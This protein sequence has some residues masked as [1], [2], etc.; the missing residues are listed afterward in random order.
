MNCKHNSRA[1]VAAAGDGAAPPSL[2][3]I[4][5]GRRMLDY[6]VA[7]AN[8]TWQR[9]AL[10][11]AARNECSVLRHLWKSVMRM[12]SDRSFPHPVHGFTLVELLVVIAIIA[13]LVALLLPAVNAAREAGRRAQCTNNLYNL[14]FATIRS[15][16]TNGFVPGWRNAVRW[17]TATGNGTHFTSWPVPLLPFIERNDVF[18]SYTSGTAPTVFVGTFSCPSSPPDVMTDA[19]LA[20]AG[21]AGSGANARRHD[22]VMLDTTDTVNGRVS[23][24]DI[25]NA[26]GTTQ[27]LLLSEKCN[28]NLTLA[29]NLWRSTGISGLSFASGALNVTPVFGI[30]GTPPLRVINSGTMGSSSVPGQLSM[31]SSNHSGGAVSAFCDGHTVFL[32]E[33]LQANVYAQL[34][35]SNN[36]AVTGAIYATGTTWRQTYNILSEGDFN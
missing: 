8:P 1:I 7:L 18:R 34:L 19:T 26:D 6:A 15:N 24:D 36:A 3:S 4:R 17:Q 14:A 22:A 12:N 25:S 27:T 29:Q 30:V 33:S 10:P 32:K 9:A 5:S 21:N 13:T 28:S 31:P 11:H 16:D 35:S 23:L 20:Y 2:R